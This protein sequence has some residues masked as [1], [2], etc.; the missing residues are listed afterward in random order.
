MPHEIHRSC[1][2]T[3][4]SGFRPRGKAR[5]LTYC[6]GQTGTV[7]L[8]KRVGH[9]GHKDRG[10]RGPRIVISGGKFPLIGGLILA[11][12]TSR[13]LSLTFYLGLL[14]LHFLRH[15]D[16]CELEQFVAESSVMATDLTVELAPGRMDDSDFIRNDRLQIRR[17]KH[18]PDQNKPTKRGVHKIPPKLSP[19]SGDC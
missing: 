16:F 13:H 12:L 10:T 6:C 2:S 19:S 5:R 4:E 1:S 3:S 14:R 9:K 17:Q 15:A 7:C 18:S 8:R 11:P